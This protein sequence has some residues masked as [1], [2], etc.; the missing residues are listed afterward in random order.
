MS[1]YLDLKYISLISGRLSLFKKKDVHLFNFRCPLCGDSSAKKNKTR[2]YFYRVSKKNV[3]SMKCHNCGVSMYFSTFLKTF[4][5]TLYQSYLLEVFK[6]DKPIVVEENVVDFKVDENRFE[7]VTLLD[8]LLDRLDTLPEDNEAVQFCLKRKIPKN[9]F[10]R[11]YFID[12]MHKIETLSYKYLNKIPSNEPRLVMPFYDMQGKLEG[13]TCR[14]LRGEELRYVTVKIVDDGLMIFGSELVNP[15]KRVYV[16]EGPI[17]SLFLPNAI[18]VGGVAFDKISRLAIPKENM[19]II[20]DNQPRNNEVVKQ[21]LKYIKN[22]YNI[23]VWPQNMIEKDINDLV[24]AG[25]QDIPALI[26]ERFSKGLEAEMR[27]TIWKRI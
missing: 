18:A 2:G 11:L 4:D 22:G 20:L 17:D 21:Y 9:V 10:N 5:S 16:T 6:D 24:L 19:I 27:I 1:I 8:K 12:D 7:P 23:F 25:Y 13:L 15:N 26:E 3:M 14:A